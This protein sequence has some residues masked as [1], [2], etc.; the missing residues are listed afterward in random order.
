MIRAL[1][2]DRVAGAALTLFGL[3]VIWESRTLPLGTLRNPGPAFLPIA[4]ALLVAGFGGVIVALGARAPRLGDVDWQGW[5]HAVAIFAA[6]GFAALA[7]ERIGYRPT[8]TI[9]LLFLVG[10]VE[11]RR[12]AGCHRDGAGPGAGHLLPLQHRAAR[13]AA[14]RSRWASDGDPAEPGSGLRG[15]ALARRAPLRVRRLRGGHARRRPSRR[16]A[17]RRHQPAPAGHLR[18]GRHPRHRDARRHLLRGHVRRLHHV[19]PDAHPRRGGLGH[20]VY[21]RLRHGP[22]GP[23]GRRPR[24]R[25]R[26]LLRRGQRERGRTHAAGSPARGLRAQVRTARVLHAPAP[27]PARPRVHERRIDAQGARHG[28]PRSDPGHGR[29]R[30]D[31]R[32]LPLRPWRGGAGR[33]DRRG[34][35]R[36]RALRARRDP[37]HGGDAHPARGDQAEACGT[38]CR[39]DRSGGNP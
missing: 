21:R 22:Q 26:R 30:P 2:T 13:T 15:G 23:R 35:G 28:R 5:R 25:G 33:R 19:D 3:F 24:H 14:A 11:R 7:L 36:G 9:T 16:G 12:A 39:R 38:C 6:C 34:P 18:P 1:T 17:A 10:V 29:D 31:D 20:D 27:R 4:L 32:V 37:G 8:V